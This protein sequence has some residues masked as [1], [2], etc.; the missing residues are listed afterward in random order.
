MQ[1]QGQGKERGT[2]SGSM[3]VSG[4]HSWKNRIANLPHKHVRMT[5][6]ER[7]QACVR[8]HEWHDCRPARQPADIESSVS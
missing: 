7:T 8:V 4:S 2:Y 1:L 6:G 3:A 5:Q